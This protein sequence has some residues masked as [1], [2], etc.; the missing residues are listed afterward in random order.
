MK[1]IY[2]AENGNAATSKLKETTCM[3]VILRSGRIKA[4]VR[5]SQIFHSIAQ[6]RRAM[7]KLCN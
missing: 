4:A 3:T 1:G 5:S 7:I 6:K 2:T